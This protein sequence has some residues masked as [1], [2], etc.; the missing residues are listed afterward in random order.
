MK[1]GTHHRMPARNCLRCDSSLEGVAC[2][3]ADAKANPNDT[4]IC[5]VCGH[6]MAFADDLSLRELNDKEATD[7][8][9]DERL[10][11]MQHVRGKMRKH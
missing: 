5:M 1:L 10:L 2:I 11:A 7:V 9:G 3:G 6:V 4:A 8:A